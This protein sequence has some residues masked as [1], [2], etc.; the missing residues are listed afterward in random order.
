MPV[1]RLC[2]HR[3][4]NAIGGNCI[5]I[6]ASGG[7]RLLLDAGR[8][9]EAP[10]RQ[11]TSVPPS[12]NTGASVAGV[13]LSHAH[14]DHCGMLGSLPENWP[15][16]CGPAT[17]SLLHLSASISGKCIHQPCFLWESGKAFSLGPF[18]ITPHLID[19]S[20]FDAYALLVT[21]DGKSILYSGDFRAQGRKGKLTRSLMRKPPRPLDILIME[22]TN[23]PA[24]G[25]TIQ[26]TPT[27]EALEKDY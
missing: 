22:G 9:L 19:H 25:G 20:A 10:D 6:V 5:E 12:L 21:V 11:P 13:L 3:A 2:I 1:P 23:L 7:E 8:P 16:Y 24:D 4:A 26:P 27:E 18:S 15:V 17:E 14:G